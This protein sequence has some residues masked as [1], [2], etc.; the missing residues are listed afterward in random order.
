MILF[1]DFLG[2]IFV[3]LPET[4]FFLVIMFWGTRGFTETFRK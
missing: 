1:T 4:F 2:I 3:L